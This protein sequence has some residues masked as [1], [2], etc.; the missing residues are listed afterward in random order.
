MG[1]YLSQDM[2]QLLVD[3]SISPAIGG[4]SEWAVFVE[5]EPGKPPVNCI[6]VY[7]TASDMWNTTTGRAGAYVNFQYRVRG[8]TYSEALTKANAIYDMQFDGLGDFNLMNITVNSRVYSTIVSLN[9]PIKID[10][11]D[12]SAFVFIINFG[13]IAP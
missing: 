6:T 13:A 11:D 1:N 5:R 9:N 7:Q 4:V 2:A 3:K 10:V 8:A 12:K